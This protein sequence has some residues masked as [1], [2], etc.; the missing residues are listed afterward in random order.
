MLRYLILTDACMLRYLIFTDTCMLRYLILTDTCMLRYLIFTDI[1]MLHYLIFA[2]ICRIRYVVFT[3]ACML[4][5]LI[6]TDTCMIRYVIFTD[7]CMLS[8]LILTDTCMLRYLIFT[9]KIY[10]EVS[11]WNKSP[12]KGKRLFTEMEP[13][14]GRRLLTLWISNV[15]NCHIKCDSIAITSSILALVACQKNWHT[16]LGCRLEEPEGMVAKANKKKK[17]EG[18]SMVNPRLVQRC[19]QLRWHRSVGAVRPN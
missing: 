6:F 1:C 16:M 8:Y 4:R 10:R 5:Y 13:S 7:T 2:D 9:G 3:D 15:F 17:E 14:L 12:K 11:C 19:Y 18:N